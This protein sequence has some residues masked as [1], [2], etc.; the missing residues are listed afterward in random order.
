[1]AKVGWFFLV[2]LDFEANYT[3]DAWKNL[4]DTRCQGKPPYQWFVVPVRKTPYIHV[5]GKIR[6]KYLDISDISLLHM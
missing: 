6:V 2:G 4:A 3:W 1:M 5:T